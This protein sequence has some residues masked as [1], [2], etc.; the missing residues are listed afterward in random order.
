MKNNGVKI[1]GVIPNNKIPDIQTNS[2]YIELSENLHIK[3]PINFPEIHKISELYIKP[4]LISN[5]IFQSISTNKLIIH[6]YYKIDLF[7]HDS[8]TSK[9]GLKSYNT[10]LPL[11][12]T[13]NLP[14]SD[15]EINNI[16][17]AL[18]FVDVLL[19]DKT[20][21]SVTTITLILLNANK[22][23]K[24]NSNFDYTPSNSL[25]NNMKNHKLKPNLSNDENLN[26]SISLAGNI[27]YA[28]SSNCKK[29]IDIINSNYYFY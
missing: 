27:S 10:K 6:G 3:L 22:P 9:I 17:S 29:N 5:K 7:Y 21:L 11:F 8:N 13:L 12:T 26:E 28:P 18:E 15:Y 23:Y 19:L 14:T 4:I 2:K 16:Y 24:N 20:S 25:N 1:Y